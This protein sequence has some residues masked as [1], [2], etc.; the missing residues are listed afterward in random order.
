MNRRQFLTRGGLA[1]A[2][3][4]TFTAA[5]SDTAE[6]NPEDV[7]D[8][9]D[10][11]EPQTYYPRRALVD[12]DLKSRGVDVERRGVNINRAEWLRNGMVRV[13]SIDG[14]VYTQTKVRRGW[15]RATAWEVAAT[16]DFADLDAARIAADL[17]ADARA[18]R[19]IPGA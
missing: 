12:A 19:F 14:W 2:A 13:Y 9:A 18:G 6:G 5:G 8:Y 4:L 16:H 15:S 10:I 3:A 11:G 1:T 7:V 17:K